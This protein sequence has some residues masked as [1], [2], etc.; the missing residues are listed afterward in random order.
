MAI[1]EIINTIAIMIIIV[2]FENVFIVSVLFLFDF[3]GVFVKVRILINIRIIIVFLLFVF[4]FSFDD[5]D[6]VYMNKVIIPEENVKIVTNAIH[7]D[8]ELLN[9]VIVITMDP[10]RI[11]IAMNTGF[12]KS[13]IFIANK[14]KSVSISIICLLIYK[15]TVLF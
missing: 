12:I 14:G 13:T 15:I 6:A 9:S 1:I 7:L 8:I 10:I 2:L 11:E 3:M 5:K 4:I